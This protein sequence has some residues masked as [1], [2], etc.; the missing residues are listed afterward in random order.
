MKEYTIEYVKEYTLEYVEKHI[1]SI[2][3]WYEGILTLL[4]GI[5][6]KAGYHQIW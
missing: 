4:G 2:T 1:P 5:N 6:I 3:P